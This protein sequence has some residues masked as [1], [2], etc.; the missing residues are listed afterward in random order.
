MRISNDAGEEVDTW[1]GLWLE[2]LLWLIRGAHVMDGDGM[3]IDD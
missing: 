3:S 2:L 1:L